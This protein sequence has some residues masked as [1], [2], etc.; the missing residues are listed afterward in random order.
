MKKNP[1]RI[2]EILE[3]DSEFVSLKLDRFYEVLRKLRYEGKQNL[4]RNL[5]EAGQMLKFFKGHLAEHMRE[6]E[7]IIFPFLETYIPRL[8]PMVYLLLS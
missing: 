6:E 5:D 7:K 2:D 4:G 3:R 8:Q 1:S